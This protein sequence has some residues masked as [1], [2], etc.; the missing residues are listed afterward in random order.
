MKNRFRVLVPVLAVVSMLL[1]G[2]FASMTA[3]YAAQPPAALEKI[4]AAKEGAGEWDPTYTV[5][6]HIL[7]PEGAVL[8]SGDVALKSPTMMAGEF[9]AAVAAQKGIAQEGIEAGYVTSLGDYTNNTTAE[10]YWLYTVNG[11]SPAVGCNQYQLRDGD[12]MVW[13]YQ[14][15][16]PGTAADAAPAPDAKSFEVG[17]DSVEAAAEGAGEW[18]PTYVV[19]LKIAAPD[20]AELFN[21]NV[22]LKSPT[23]WAS[24]FLEAALAA[25]NVSQ[26]GLEQGYVTALGDYENNTALN[27]YWMYYVNGLMPKM[28]CNQYQLRGGDYMSWSYELYK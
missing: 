5:E 9:L 3:A 20:G 6:V 13:E 27:M 22:S 28:G 15:Y 21:G 14:K 24:E 25:K 12:V 16:Q 8:F 11:F 7:A 26:A 17:S 18:D 4:E 10:T 1:I 19:H 2:S 23:M